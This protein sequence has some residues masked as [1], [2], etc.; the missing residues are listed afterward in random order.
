MKKILFIIFIVF[1]YLN[2]RYLELGFLQNYSADEYAFHGSFLNMFEGVMS[3][4]IKKIFTFN[5][6]SYGF[7]FFA[8][9]LFAISPFIAME[10]WEMTIYIPRLIVSLFAISSIY[11]IFKIAK[12]YLDNISSILI[13]L[14]AISMPGFWI[15]SFML[16]PNW[17][18]TFFI[19]LTIYYL[20]KDAWKNEN[21]F[22]WGSVA[23]GLAIATKIQAI[24]F[25]PL[26]FLYIFY[27]NLQNKINFNFFLKLKLFIKTLLL[28][29]SVFVLT[30]PY[31]IH[32]VGFK[33]FTNS[34][35][36]AL[37]SNT[38][39]HG[40]VISYSITEKIN[41][42]INPF[43]FDK[44]IFIIFI[45]I[46]LFL[47]LKILKKND[48]KNI[49]YIVA[50]YFFINICYMLIFVNKDWQQYYLPLLITA[51]LLLIPLIKKYEKIKFYILIG[52]LMIQV[53]TYFPM[54]KIIFLKD[55]GV[56][57]K[58]IGKNITKKELMKDISNS[59]INDLKNHITKDTN[60]LIENGIPF[61][62]LSLGLSYHNI[63]IIYGPLQKSM[64]DSEAY[65]KSSKLKNLKNFKEIEFIILSKTSIY[66]KEEKL[67]QVV[68][69]DGYRN[70]RKIVEDFINVGD[71]G[72]EIFK[73]NNYFYIFRKK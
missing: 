55:Y 57:K 50:F 54:Y 70:A 8:L 47:S 52:L 22:W 30:N 26:I 65:L 21:N 18:M 53:I 27:D 64:F 37:A 15:N 49:F 63:Q 48:S 4:D 41:N 23:F 12:D 56:P 16:R 7:S 38:T 40:S 62:F 35:L 32:P 34:F 69:K 6:Y 17:M 68:N 19:I 10:N 25:I 67:K 11:L 46:S 60:I 72:Y 13:S 14:I 36:D 73:K 71:L 66:F 5:F 24:T 2:Y 42:A 31:I 1:A 44:Y 59:L 9:N 20:S 43:Y 29:F 39:N 58:V 61:D 51:P 28:S 3:L 33:A 45:L